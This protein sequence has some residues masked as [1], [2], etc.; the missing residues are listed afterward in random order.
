VAAENDA[1]VLERD[2]FPGVRTLEDFEIR[3]VETALGSRSPTG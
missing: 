1:V 2:K 3:H